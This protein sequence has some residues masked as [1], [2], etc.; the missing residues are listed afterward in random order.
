MVL[1]RN[2]DYFFGETEQAAFHTANVVPGID[3]TNDPLL[4][5]RNFSYLDTQLIR[6]GGPNFAQLPVN[7]PIAEVNTNQRDGY[8]QSRVHQG[9]TAYFKNTLGGGCP[10]IAEAEVFRHYQEKVDGHKIRKRAASFQDH[11]SQATLFWNSMSDWERE[12]IVAAFRFE[13]GKVDHLHIR[14]AVIEQLNR[15]DHRLAVQVAEG[16]GVKPPT[17]DVQPNHGRSSPALSQANT[18][19]DSIRSRKVAVL[20]ADGVE[21][22]P[23][24]ALTEALRSRDAI[25]ELLAPTDGAVRSSTGEELA[26]DRAMTTMASV[27]YDAVVVASGAD[28]ASTLGSDGYALHFIAEA[29]K[30]AK[31]VAAL[32]AGAELV[33]RATAGVITLSADGGAVANEHGVLGA[34]SARTELPDGFVESFCDLLAGHRVWTRP[35]AAIPG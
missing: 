25:P 34:P 32:G 21:A 12:H 10:A 20:V 2:P 4:Q 17:E 14:E 3:F 23:V 6:L 7:R 30:H 15:V 26:V 13:L 1:N 5:M 24:T 18:A 22:G 9:R 19:T 29:A 35:T 11:Y 28:A 16:V 27:L 8:H 33:G 31:P